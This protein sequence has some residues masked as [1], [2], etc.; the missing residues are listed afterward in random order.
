MNFSLAQT[1]RN[2]ITNYKKAKSAMLFNPF[3]P[4]GIHF[5]V[6]RAIVV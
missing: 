2:K 3:K 4:S 1:K 5:K 6:F